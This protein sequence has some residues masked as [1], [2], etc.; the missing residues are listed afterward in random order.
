MHTT[1][2]TA[3]Q[4]GGTAMILRGNCCGRLYRRGSDP[5]GRITWM[6]LHGKGAG[7]IIIVTA[8]RV[9]KNKGITACPDTAYMREWEALREQGNLDPDPRN[10]VL[11]NISKL[12]YEW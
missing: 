7:C 12:L 11:N 5:L 6:A 2:D 3:Y 10:Q 9:C 8:Y 1:S 4:P